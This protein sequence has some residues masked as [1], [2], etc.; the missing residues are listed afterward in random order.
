[1]Q[2]YIWISIRFKAYSLIPEDWQAFM[3]RNVLSTIKSKTRRLKDFWYRVYRFGMSFS[4]HFVRQ[5]TSAKCFLKDK[6]KT[7]IEEKYLTTKLY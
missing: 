4:L 2:F 3:T 6:I 5:I 1:M 7:V